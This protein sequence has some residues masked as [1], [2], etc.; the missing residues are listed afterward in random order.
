MAHQHQAVAATESS[1]VREVLRRAGQP[2][3]A[4]VRRPMEARFGHD[5]G[6]VR[7]HVDGQAAA[8]AQAVGAHAYTVGQHIVFGPG[9]YRPNSP[10]GRSLLAHEL[11]H[12]L[13]Q[14]DAVATASPAALI[15]DAP[16]SHPLL[17]RQPA[18][19]PTG[20]AVAP[21]ASGSA[22]PT[23][24][25]TP[26]STQGSPVTSQ[27]QSSQWSETV[28]FIQF[29]IDDLY[30]AMIN[31]EGPYLYYSYIGHGWSRNLN[32]SSDLNPAPARDVYN[33]EW[34]LAPPEPY[35]F[36]WA[37]WNKFHIDNSS[38]LLPGIYNS[39]EA[40]ADIKF[41]TASGNGGFEYHFVDPK[42]K[43]LPPLG[44]FSNTLITTPNLFNTKHHIISENGVLQ[45]DAYLRV[46]ASSLQPPP[47]KLEV[48]GPPDCPDA[49][50]FKA[51]W[52]SRSLRIREPA[53][54]EK[55]LDCQVEIS[56]TAGGAK[57]TLITTDVN[58]VK[59][60]PRLVQ[61]ASCEEVADVFAFIIGFMTDPVLGQSQ[62]GLVRVGL[63]EING[64][65]SVK[66]ERPTK[67]VK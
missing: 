24:G 50:Y 5:F 29:G 3:A 67:K 7:V 18:Q 57:G 55:A 2:L 52:K 16:L 27:G 56:K 6:R 47:V 12:V 32:F 28:P 54:N 44:R 10:H 58:G 63:I 30:G 59:A 43:Y 45:W 40:R 60:A 62:F 61:E 11:T 36:Q 23:Q 42:P 53:P 25:A 33:A 20:K 34:R 66:F 1:T 35:D 39:F 49:S 46:E 8:S 4:E 17:Q 31:P 37:F 22:A 38:A 13:Q 26:A 65:Q 21:A 14:R 48:I 9:Q 15:Q 41:V 64:T 51:K 19:Q